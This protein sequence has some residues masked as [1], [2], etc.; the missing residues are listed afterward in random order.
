MTN[1]SPISI[2]FI[3]TT[4][5]LCLGYL[6]KPHSLL[7]QIKVRSHGELLGQYS[8]GDSICYYSVKRVIDGFLEQP[9]YQD[10]ILVERITPYRDGY[11]LKSTDVSTREEAEKYCGFFLGIS[12]VEAR[13]KFGGSSEPYLFEYL[14]LKIIDEKTQKLIGNVI[15]IEEI[16]KKVFLIVQLDGQAKEV[17]LP[18]ISDY[19]TKKDIEN[20]VLYSQGLHE[21][22]QN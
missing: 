4:Q 18:I 22:V 10:N 20:R 11:L 5:I 9:R 2:G 7:G 12:L 8:D 21:L 14:N 17:M 16:Q 15:R 3:L 19:V 1:G 6:K 13:E